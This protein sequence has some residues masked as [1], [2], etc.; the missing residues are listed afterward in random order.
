MSNETNVTDV[1][2]ETFV[3]SA[4][5]DAGD[6]T[7]KKPA[8]AAENTD[9]GTSTDADQ[10]PTTST[11]DTRAD[12]DADAQ[13][14]AQGDAERDQFPRAV[15]EKLRKESAGY[16]ERARDAEER[17]DAM[18]ARLHRAMVEKDGRLADADDLEF[19]AEH[20][21]DADAMREAITE[22]I[23]RKP[24]LKARRVIGDIG[25][26]DRGRADNQGG[27]LVSIMRGLQ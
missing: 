7:G 2:R 15:V 14:D 8:P 27:D 13:G 9:A 17:A 21:D 5:T 11:T 25:A 6:T 10:T 22:L 20:L 19:N 3:N 1:S 4:P 18:A 12:D 23:R 26:G 24:H 16:R